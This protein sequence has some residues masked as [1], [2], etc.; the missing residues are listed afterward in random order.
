MYDTAGRGHFEDLILKLGALSDGRTYKAFWDRHN[1]QRQDGLPA[2][3]GSHR[4]MAPE[5]IRRRLEQ[6]SKV[7]P[8]YG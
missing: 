7:V 4:S 1:K 2:E 8:E 3:S 5:R 6:Y